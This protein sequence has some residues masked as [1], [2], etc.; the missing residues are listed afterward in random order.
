MFNKFHKYLTVSSFQI[1]IF[2]NPDSLLWYF[3]A[4]RTRFREQRRFFVIPAFLFEEIGRFVILFSM[5][6]R[7]NLWKLFAKLSESKWINVKLH[8]KHVKLQ[9]FT[10]PWINIEKINK[11]QKN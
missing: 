9:E 10:I 6:V 8:N 2:F 1:W 11:N 5:R 4:F 3:Y 7:E